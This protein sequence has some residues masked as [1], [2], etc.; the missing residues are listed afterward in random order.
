MKASLIRLKWYTIILPIAFLAVAQAV[1]VLVAN[2][3][4]STTSIHLLATAVIAVCVVVFSTVVFRVIGGMQ[5]KIVRQNEELSALNAVSTAVAGS[6]ELEEAVT[7]ALDNVMAVTKASVG[8]IVVESETPEDEPLQVSRGGDLAPRR[9]DLLCEAT[10][11][12]Q[13]D[14]GDGRGVRIIALS[15]VEGAEASAALADGFATFACVPLRVQN[16]ALGVIRLLAGGELRTTQD[17]ERLLAAIGNQ[18]AV[19]IQAS[20]L[21]HDVLRRASESQALYEIGLDIASL[22]DVQK[23]LERIVNHAKEALGSETAALCLARNHGRG[24]TLASSSGPERAFLRS[25]VQPSPLSITVREGPQPVGGAAAPCSALAEGYRLCHLSAPLMVG[26][27]TIGEICV[28]SRERRQFSERHRQLLAGLAD[29]AAI[30]INNA[31]LL[32]SER[33]V[34]V[35]EERQRLSR[36]MHDSLAQVL[37][38]LHLKAQVAGRSLA[39]D[40]APA[41][42]E[43]VEEIASL[44]REAYRDVREAILD[45]RE[46]VSPELGIVGTLQEFTRKFSRQTGIAAEV[47][48]LSKGTPQLTPDVEIQLLRVIQE[49]M[50][51]VRKH[52]QAGRVCI[53]VA[54]GEDAVCISVEDDGRGF[55]YEA[56]RADDRG[57]LGMQVM[58]ERVERLGGRFSVESRPGKGTHV[59]IEFSYQDG[60]TDGSR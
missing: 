14:A 10:H 15:R 59:R 34:A 5:Q 53:R 13:H 27:S 9:L 58:R 39:Q 26:G 3:T 57:R 36:E 6:L 18:I 30:A 38:Y 32:E 51:N 52:S 4:A 29:M 49:A 54:P 47:E 19:A 12:R 42:A 40:D 35:L 22:Q 56:I 48:L 28:S 46:R 24:M 16:R 7:R 2:P 8:E 31:R 45:L 17:S 20:H 55:D 25:P 23:I 41:A 1:A 11:G 44:A 21:F 33:H 37:G 50:T 60:G 43:E